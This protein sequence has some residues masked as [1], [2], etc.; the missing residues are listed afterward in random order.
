M[1]KKQLTYEQAIKELEEIV[2][3][4]ESNSLGLDEIAGQVD[5]AQKLIVYCR[6]KLTKTDA[7]I[8]KLLN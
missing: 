7:D 5:R 8:Q 3:L 1:G 4:L 2:R 6:E